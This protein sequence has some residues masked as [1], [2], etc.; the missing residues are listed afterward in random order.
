MEPADYAALPRAAEFVKTISAS[1]LQ[2]DAACSG[3]LR[4]RSE[5]V[6]K[7]NKRWFVLWP[8]SGSKWAA[9]HNETKWAESHGPDRTQQL[10]LYYESET[11]PAPKGIIPLQ[12]DR[13]V[14]ENE[15]GNEYRG[16]EVVVLTVAV[17]AAA[18]QRYVIRSDEPGNPRDLPHWVDLIRQ[19]TG[20]ELEHS[21]LP[22]VKV[23][24]DRYYRVDC[25]QRRKDPAVTDVVAWR[26]S[27]HLDD[28]LSEEEDSALGAGAEHGTV[29][30]AV[31][32]LGLGAS[33]ERALAAEAL[34]AADGERQ[35]GGDGHAGIA[36]RRGGRRDGR[37]RAH[38]RQR[39]RLAAGGGQDGR[40]AAGQEGPL[41]DPQ[42][43]RAA[44]A[45]PREPERPGSPRRRG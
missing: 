1:E 19:G 28:K 22:T 10:L 2:A 21:D 31:V 3:W 33:G 4:K 14:A 24:E 11:A 29:W 17:E 20:A 39:A 45:E 7:W 43:G 8:A 44:G 23:G 27:P 34:P 35:L 6:K 36:A 12:P 16:E 41:L 18:H 37:R 15:A 30:K 40:R 32:E 5:H 13:F 38:A 26:K 9:K 25:P 42:P